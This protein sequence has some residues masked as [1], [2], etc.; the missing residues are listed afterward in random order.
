M[1]KSIFKKIT[2]NQMFI[3]LVA[4]LLLAVKATLEVSVFMERPAMKFYFL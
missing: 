1:N 3:P 4:L 2:G